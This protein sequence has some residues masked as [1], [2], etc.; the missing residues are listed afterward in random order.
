LP[1]VLI[2]LAIYF[3]LPDSPDESGWLS[4]AERNWLTGELARDAARVGDIPHQHVLASLRNPLV[5]WLAAMSLLQVGAFQVFGMSAP[6]VLKA[7]AGLSNAEVGYL[8]SLGGIFCA[9]SMLS[10]GW[11]CDLLSERFKLLL[12]VLPIAALSILVIAVAPWPLAVIAAY[13]IFY[14]ANG[15]AIVAQITIWTDLLPVRVLGVCIAAINTVT[16]MG[17]FAG[18]TG[19]GIV[20]DATGSFKAGLLIFP[21]CYLSALVLSALVMRQLNSRSARAGASATQP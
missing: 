17:V 7:E 6:M 5:A 3:F 18:T 4:E 16:Q 2:G 11:L 10:M 1:A 13:L 20:R 9:L 19:F 21:V 12:A 15:G 8:V 14:A